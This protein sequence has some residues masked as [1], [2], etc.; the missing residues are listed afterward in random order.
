[1]ETFTIN[2]K[3]LSDVLDKLE[4]D[5]PSR[6]YGHIDLL[7]AN[8][9]DHLTQFLLHD[10]LTVELDSGCGQAYIDG[11]PIT[12]PVY[13]ICDL[14]KKPSSSEKLYEQIIKAKKEAEKLGIYERVFGKVAETDKM[15]DESILNKNPQEVQDYLNEL[16]IAV[17]IKGERLEKYEKM[18]I[19]RCGSE[20]YA[21]MKLFVEE[22]Q[23]SAERGKFT[24]TSK[25]NLSYLGKN[26]GLSENIVNKIIQHFE[27]EFGE[28]AFW[29]QCRPNEKTGYKNYLDKYPNGKYASKAREILAEIEM[30]ERAEREGRNFWDTPKTISE[31]LQNLID[32][33]VEEIVLEGRPFDDCKKYLPRYCESEGLDYEALEKGITE[34]VETLREMKTSDS[35]TLVRLALFQAREC[36]VTEA[37]VIRLAEQVK[38]VPK[39][40]EDIA[41]FPAKWNDLYG[42]I[43]VAGNMVIKPQYEE[44]KEFF[45]GLAAVNVNGKFGFIDKKGDLVIEPR[46][47]WVHSGFSEDRVAVSIGDKDYIIIDRSGNEIVHDS[48][49]TCIIDYYSEGL[50]PV[51]VEDAL[52]GFVD[53]S[54]VMVI[55]PQFKFANSFSE[56][57]S[58]VD[59][60]GRKG[61]IDHTGQLQIPNRYKTADSFSEGL[62]LTTVLV[63]KKTAGLTFWRSKEE[64]SDKKYGFINKNGDV[65]IEHRFEYARS[66][67]DGLAAVK[68]KEKWGFVDRLGNMV[69]NANYSFVENFSE[70]LVGF[71]LSN[72]SSKYGYMDKTG[73]VVIEP[74]FATAFEFKNGLAHVEWSAI[75]T[76]YIDRSGRTVFVES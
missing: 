25:V 32:A 53:K 65:V 27:V 9:K 13:A 43:D 71:S 47:K 56:G 72:S 75:K 70:G 52:W 33:M 62:A 39:V 12:G 40:D 3:E 73:R 42:F 48:H 60:E 51:K 14:D 10:T 66:F 31:D 69:I 58:A 19:K 22:V 36:H 37:L 35:Q 26:A 61:F 23:R 15:E 59:F 24:N 44:V 45:E 41:L 64:N 50:C 28:E 34:L 17:C 29:N 4:E 46:Y 2:Y 54:G 7:R 76:G 1:M 21:N 74:Q 30:K 6:M 18:A 57:L 55:K 8:I 5:H 67:S 20:S 16:A 68:T 38:T 49:Y 63:E 11:K